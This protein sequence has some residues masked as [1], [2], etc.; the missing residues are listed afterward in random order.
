[1]N[2]IVTILFMAILALGFSTTAN[3]E[4]MK[5]GAGKCGSSM[6]KKASS[7]DTNNPKCKCGDNCQ[8]VECKCGQKCPT[9]EKKCDSKKAP[10]SKCGSK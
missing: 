8:C 2:K 9:S 7:C 1:M 3:A 10:A 6:M 5:C 4:G